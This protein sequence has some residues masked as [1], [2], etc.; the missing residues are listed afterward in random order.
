MRITRV[1]KKQKKNKG[2]CRI[3]QIFLVASAAQASSDFSHARA[4]ENR[5]NR[6]LDECLS[7]WLPR[8]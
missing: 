3:K 2:R 1:K 5:E 4:E 7:V 8:P 6:T